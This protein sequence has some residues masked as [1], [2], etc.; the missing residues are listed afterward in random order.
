MSSLQRIA[1]NNMRGTTPDNLTVL[2][3]TRFDEVSVQS[4]PHQSFQTFGKVAHPL[5]RLKMDT[6][7]KNLERLDDCHYF[8]LSKK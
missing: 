4:A 1:V 8:Y 5:L 2:W 3:T 7:R 6:N